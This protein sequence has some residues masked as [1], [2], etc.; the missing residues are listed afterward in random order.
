MA[1]AIKTFF[2]RVVVTV[3]GFDF[4]GGKWLMTVR[5]VHNSF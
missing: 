5:A 3:R 2:D 1:T 4:Q